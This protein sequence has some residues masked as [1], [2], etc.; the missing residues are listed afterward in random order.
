MGRL[1]AAVQRTK[2]CR[3]DSVW[4]LQ[5]LENRD[6]NPTGSKVAEVL[7]GHYGRK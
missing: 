6:T 2:N 3:V 1:R 7:C 5:H 4:T